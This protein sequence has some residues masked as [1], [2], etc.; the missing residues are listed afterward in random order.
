[1]MMNG[2]TAPPTGASRSE[3]LTL[4]SQPITF[5]HCPI[6]IQGLS[7]FVIFGDDVDFMRRMAEELKPGVSSRQLELSG[8]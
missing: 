8:T 1:M 7:E 4:L 5:E 2:T 3:A 6:K